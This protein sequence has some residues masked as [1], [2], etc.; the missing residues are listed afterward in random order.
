MSPC[1]STVFL[2]LDNMLCCYTTVQFRGELGAHKHVKYCHSQYICKA[3]AFKYVVTVGCCLS[4]LF[5]RLL[6][7]GELGWVFLNVIIR[8]ITHSSVAFKDD[9][10]GM[11]FSHC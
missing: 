10:T 2:K 1:I 9:Y 11:G 8:I 4:H 6:F 5:L 7:S 3:G